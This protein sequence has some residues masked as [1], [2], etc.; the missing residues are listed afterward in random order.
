[1]AEIDLGALHGEGAWCADWA[2]KLENGERGRD[3]ALGLA[4]ALAPREPA[5]A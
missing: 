1:M 4:E 3:Y 5:S 2:A